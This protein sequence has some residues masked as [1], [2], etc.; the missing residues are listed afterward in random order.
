MRR[1][2]AQ[3]ETTYQVRLEFDKYSKFGA[4]AVLFMIRKTTSTYEDGSTSV[5][6]T[7]VKEDTREYQTLGRMYVELNGPVSMW[8][9]YDRLIKEDGFVEAKTI[10]G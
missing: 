2:E 1:T 8:R 4:G 10:I 6:T 3:S 7:Y 5:D 9:S